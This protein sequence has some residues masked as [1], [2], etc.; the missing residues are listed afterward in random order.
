MLND[1]PTK[2]AIYKNIQDNEALGEELQA[3]L[4]GCTAEEIFVDAQHPYQALKDAAQDD[5]EK[6]VELFT[7]H[8]A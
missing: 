6:V 1:K 4:C 2:N 3:L 8:S 7:R 5:W